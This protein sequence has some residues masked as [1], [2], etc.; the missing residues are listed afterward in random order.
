MTKSRRSFTAEFKR[1]VTDLVLKNGALCTS[2][3]GD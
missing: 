1:D 3:V 2:E